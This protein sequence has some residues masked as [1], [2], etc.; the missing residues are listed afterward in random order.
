MGDICVPE[1]HL[2]SRF[3][4]QG[5]IGAPRFQTRA[6]CLAPSPGCLVEFLVPPLISF[7]LVRLDLHLS[8]LDLLVQCDLSLYC[9]CILTTW[10]GLFKEEFLEQLQGAF[11]YL[12]LL[13]HV[14]GCPCLSP[15]LSLL[16][17]SLGFP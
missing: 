10:P 4:L 13:L 8:V 11:V 12:C 15:S 7:F 6:T 2:V 5:F 14:G 16:L 3:L 1:L 9:I 17:P